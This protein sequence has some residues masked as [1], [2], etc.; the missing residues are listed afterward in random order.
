M[1]TPGTILGLIFSSFECML[2]SIES[3]GRAE[4]L[5]PGSFL[6]KL[7]ETVEIKLI[8]DVEYCVSAS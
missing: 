6:R 1:Y 4:N 7:D 3:I 5:Y 2:W 8:F